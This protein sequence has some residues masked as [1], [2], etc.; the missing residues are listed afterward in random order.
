MP[1]LAL[2]DG[3]TLAY[4]DTG[5]GSA[6][7]VLRAADQS[8]ADLGALS[9]A[10]ADV[11]RVIVPHGADPTDLEG[12]GA[13]AAALLRAL[14]VA[15]AIIIGIG[16]G[17]SAALAMGAHEAPVVHRVI[18]DSPGLPLTPESVLGDIMCH[19]L[20]VWGDGDPA[21]SDADKSR[22]ALQVPR[23]RRVTYP[24]RG[25]G[26]ATHRV[27]FLEDLRTW[28]QQDPAPAQLPMNDERPTAARGPVIFDA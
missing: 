10:L 8:P 15:P 22:I 4:D 12:T 16:A 2:P 28:V 6:V 14:D 11:A 18:A 23:V 21:V 27:Q 3:R 25:G 5:A 20:L 9:D 13:D 1:T 26:Y 7:L 24:A 19:V 17:A